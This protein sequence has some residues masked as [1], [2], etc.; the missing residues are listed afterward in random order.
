MYIYMYIYTYTYTFIN[1]QPE[2]A[3]LLFMCDTATHCNTHCNT[4]Q[5]TYQPWPPVHNA[6][7]RVFFFYVSFLCSTHINHNSIAKHIY[8]YSRTA[9]GGTPIIYVATDEKRQ[10]EQAKV[11]ALGGVL[12]AGHSSVAFFD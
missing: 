2:G 3:R 11:R 1:E 9:G 12:W 6:Y 4:L 7:Y 10:E 5:H 8:I